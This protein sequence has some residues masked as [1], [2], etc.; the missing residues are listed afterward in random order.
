MLATRLYI[1]YRLIRSYLSIV[2]HTGIAPRFWWYRRQGRHDEIERITARIIRDWSHHLFESFG[3]RV[4]IEGAELV[5]LQGPLVVMCNHQSMYDIPLLM[6]Y[7]GRAPGFVA[8]Q[9]LFRIPALSYWMRAIGSVSLDRKD[10]RAGRELFDQL[11]AR[12]RREGRCYVLFPEGTRTRDPLGRI[13]PFRQGAVRLATEHDIPILPLSIDGTRL[14]NGSEALHRSRPGDR[15]IRVRVAPL[16]APVGAS[17]LAR[18]RLMED[19]REIIVSNWERIR[20]DWSPAA[21]A[22]ADAP[23]IGAARDAEVS[24]ALAE[25]G[26]AARGQTSP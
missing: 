23:R 17:S 19:L 24:E 16:M 4:E 13:G 22:A 7:L 12:I 26:R 18:K 6:G 5:P 20:V 2:F 8:K 15:V 14:L 10:P 11:G 3:C 1:V 21:Q 9:E 25:P